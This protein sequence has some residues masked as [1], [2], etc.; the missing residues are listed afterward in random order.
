V[1]RLVAQELILSFVPAPE[2]RLWRTVTRTKIQLT[3]NRVQLQRLRDTMKRSS[4]CRQTRRW[5][6][7]AGTPRRRENSEAV[8][9]LC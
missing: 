2:Q 1:K 6:L 5:M 3:R 4:P 7:R 8:G 9:V